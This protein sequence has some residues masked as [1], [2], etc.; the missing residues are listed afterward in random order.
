MKKGTFLAAAVAVPLALAASAH[1]LSVGG[2]VAT[3]GNSTLFSDNSAEFIINVDGSNIGGNATITTGDILIT[4]LGINTV[5]PTTIGSGTAY[6][7]ITA[8]TAVKIASAGDVDLGPVGP[9]DSFGTQNIDLW[10]YT[11]APLGAGDVGYFDWATGNILGGALTFGTQ[12]GLTNDDSLFALVY[13]DAGKDYNRDSDIQTGLTSASN[14]TWRLQLGFVDAGDFLS[15]I[16]PFNTASFGTIPGVTAVDNSNIALD[17]TIVAQNWPGLLF[18]EN[19]TA[20][21]GGVSSP[22]AASGF[23]IFDNLDFTLTAS[24]VPEPGTM[25][26]LGS[27]LL[28]L[29]GIG[30]KRS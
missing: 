5:G 22:S 15:V 19:F 9:D 4:I 8:I 17:G 1:A 14:G 24:A 16:A 25:I 30:R 7:E 10:Q 20:G 18:N 12:A 11:A 29:A 2:L 13:E 23:P 27:G 28:G 26:L 3:D 6:N 21:N